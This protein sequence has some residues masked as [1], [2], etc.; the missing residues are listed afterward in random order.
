[1]N[2]LQLAVMLL[3]FVL[4]ALVAIIAFFFKRSTSWGQSHSHDLHMSSAPEPVPYQINREL[5]DLD[6]TQ[7]K[8]Q[9]VTKRM[10]VLVDKEVNKQSEQIRGEMNKILETKDLALKKIQD[11]YD[12]VQNSYHK[13]G[14]QKKQTEAV[15]QAIAKGMIVTN[16]EGKIVFVNPVAEKILGVRSD[17]IMGKSISSVDGEHVISLI[18]DDGFEDHRLPGAHHSS[19]N[20]ELIKESTAIIQNI[21]GQTKGTVSIMTGATQK[22]KVDEYKNEILANI[23][24][25][26]RTPLVCIQKCIQAISQ[27]LENAPDRQKNYLR[28]AL[29]N[30]ER[31]EK[32]V[33]DILDIS[34]LEAG[35]MALR[36]QILTAQSFIEE[37]KNTFLAWA[38]DKKIDIILDLGREPIVFEADPDRLRQALVNLVANALKFTPRGGK[39]TI[40][41]CLKS[42]PALSKSTANDYIHIGV[43]DTGAGISEGEQSHIFQ[44]FAVASTEP[45]EGEKGTGLGLTIAKEIV[46]LHNGRLWVESKEGEGCYFYFSI[47]SRLPNSNAAPEQLPDALSA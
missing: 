38:K 36:H 37:I 2:E 35:K 24:H 5:G 34:K 22:K 20:K 46:E 41:A 11:K 13:L 44:K 23:T 18:N 29:R 12:T 33:N 43:R 21:S 39:I 15:I 25:E 30:A 1:V 42:E 17:E 8:L 7:E 26:L 47:P 45:T 3:C 9:Q 19:E 31:L 27:E 10:T 40:D 4:L 6:I 14:K 16:D 32:M 28:M